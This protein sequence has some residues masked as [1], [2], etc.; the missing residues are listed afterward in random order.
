MVN[1]GKR[2]KCLNANSATPPAGGFLAVAAFLDRS[3]V[4]GWLKIDDFMGEFKMKTQSPLTFPIAKQ[5]AFVLWF[6]NLPILRLG[7]MGDVWEL[8]YTE[9]FK[10]QLR[11]LPIVC[12]AR[13]PS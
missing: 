10:A 5:A 11:L 12:H 6:R 7:L 3:F 8:A 2:L 9:Q 1:D 4:K 13:K